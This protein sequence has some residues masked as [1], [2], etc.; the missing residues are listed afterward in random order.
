MNVDH[1]ISM[2]IA[3][4]KGG[5]FGLWEIVKVVKEELGVQKNAEIWSQSMQI[6][7]A[8]LQ[9]GIRAGDSPYTNRGDFV[10]WPDNELEAIVARIENEWVNSSREPNLPDSPWFGPDA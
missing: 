8:L 2:F 3:Q 9:S 4:G 5:P 7:R 1:V 6:V 10:A